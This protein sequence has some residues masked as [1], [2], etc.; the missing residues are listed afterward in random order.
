M[1]CYRLAAERSLSFHSENSARVFFAFLQTICWSILDLLSRLFFI[2]LILLDYIFSQNTA[3]LSA[4]RARG[5]LF[6]DL[7]KI[8]LSKRFL[9]PFPG[10]FHG[11][12]RK[13]GK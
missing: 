7:A 12:K 8:Y 3:P 10:G 9:T 5:A 1:L 2:I 13:I 4:A 6:F 11:A